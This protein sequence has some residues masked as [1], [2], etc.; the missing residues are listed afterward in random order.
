MGKNTS[1]SLGDHF[2]SFIEYTVQQ[3]RFSNASE[4]VRAGL[5]LLEEEEAR[6]KALKTEVK[7]GL[8]SGRAVKF[9]SKKHLTDLKHKRK[10]GKTPLHTAS[11]K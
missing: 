4:V 6:I 8:K 7:K 5:R 1:I 9:N 2:E 10:N 3:G 11:H